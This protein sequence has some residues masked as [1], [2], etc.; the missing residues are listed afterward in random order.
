MVVRPSLSRL[1]PD[2]T[3]FGYE[4]HKARTYTAS[5]QE[6]WKNKQISPVWRQ[7]LLRLKNPFPK[8]Q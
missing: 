5:V 7:Y 3:Y 4:K 6:T 2:H 1:Y 8:I